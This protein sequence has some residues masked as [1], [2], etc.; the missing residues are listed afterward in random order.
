MTVLDLS[1]DAY[2]ADDTGDTPTLS[3]SIARILC[4]KTP[5]HAKAAHP[6][7]NPDY[8]RKAEDKF[9]VGTAFHS[10][11]L[12]GVDLVHVVHANDWRTKDA[13]AARDEARSYGRI[14]L[15]AKQ[16][17]EVSLMLDAVR[18]QLATLRI[19]PAPFS[20]GTPEQ[21]IVWD[22]DGVR[23]RAR[24]DWL[25]SGGLLIDDLKT[26]SASAEP[27]AW[28]KTMYGMGADVQAAFYIRGVQA[29]FGH[30]FV[31][32]RFVVAE[33][34][35]PYAISLIDLSP[36]ALALANEKVDHAVATWRR[37]LEE[38]RWPAYPSRVASVDPPGWEEARW[39]E[40]QAV[41]EEMAV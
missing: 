30:T 7:L 38:D 16:W 13:Q 28:R 1:A 37:C 36:A 11:L 18:A 5:A 24:L 22:E 29:V 20:N 35:P 19:Q 25:H 41:A 2:H 39:L 12:Q 15:L 6:R 21:T 14:P 27:D 33:T 10:L 4:A 9:D 17:N 26:T 23:C 32:F 8:E 40:R 31:D 3:A 34:Y